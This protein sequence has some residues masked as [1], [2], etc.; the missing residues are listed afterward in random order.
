MTRF[1]LNPLEIAMLATRRL[2][3]PLTLEKKQ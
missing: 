1:S 2:P 3:T